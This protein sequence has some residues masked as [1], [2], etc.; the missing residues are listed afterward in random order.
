MLQ[1]PDIEPVA[2]TLGPFAVH[3]YGITYLLAFAGFWFFSRIRAR[4]TF[5]DW[6][7]EQI[8]DLLFYGALGVIIGGRLGYTLFYNLDQFIRDP[9]VL[10]QIQQGGM[11]FHGG[12][13]GVLAAMWIYGRKHQREFFEISTG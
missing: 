7:P 2:F 1:Y 3:W 11:S 6:K 4:K 8:D 13:L 12:L 9:L 10:L 5:F